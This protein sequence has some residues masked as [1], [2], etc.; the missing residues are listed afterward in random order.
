MLQQ[1]KATSGLYNRFSICGI[2]LVFRLNEIFSRLVIITYETVL[3]VQAGCCHP[4][5]VVARFSCRLNKILHFWL[6]QSIVKCMSVTIDGGWI[7]NWI[8]WKLIQL[9]TT[10]T[11]HCHTQS[12]TVSISR[13]LAD[14]SNGRSFL[15]SGFPTYHRLQL[16]ASRNNWTAPL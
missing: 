15:S 2:Q 11:N 12:V 9:V 14:A 10:F 16:S 4:N 3:K 5:F 8:Y 13:C 1:N 6:H 7:R